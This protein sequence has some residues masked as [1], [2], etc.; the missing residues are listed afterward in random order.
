MEFWVFAAPPPTK[1][2]LQFPRF[3]CIKSKET[4]RHVLHKITRCSLPS[5]LNHKFDSRVYRIFFELMLLNKYQTNVQTDSHF[6]K[7]IYKLQNMKS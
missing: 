6:S 3:R 4:R 7:R 5:S 2:E 1:W